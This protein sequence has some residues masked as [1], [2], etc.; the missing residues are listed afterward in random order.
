MDLLL[1]FHHQVLYML[2]KYPCCEFGYPILS[3]ITGIK[4][5]HMG[6]TD[7][8]SGAALGGYITDLS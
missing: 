2:E 8:W 4:Q 1:C 3:N 6:G 5:G 7:K